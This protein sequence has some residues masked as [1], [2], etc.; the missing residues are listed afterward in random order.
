MK[1]TVDT[2]HDSHED[3]RK[4]ISL[5]SAMLDK[6]RTS[7]QVRDIFASSESTLPLETASSSSTST[8]SNPSTTSVTATNEGGMFAMFD[9]PS[10]PTESSSDNSQSSESSDEPEEPAIDGLELY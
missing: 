2:S 5:L 9:T 7:G 4:V 3:I 6:P 8:T 1:I 10:I